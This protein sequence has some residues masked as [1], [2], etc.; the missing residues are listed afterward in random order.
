M[1]I[2]IVHPFELSILNS[3]LNEEARI[4]AQVVALGVA[5]GVARAEISRNVIYVAK[6]VD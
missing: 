6:C 2:N 4:V 5:F 1:L 3:K